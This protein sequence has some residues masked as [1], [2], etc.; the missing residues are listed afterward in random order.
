MAKASDEFVR[1][2]GERLT[3]CLTSKETNGELLEMEVVYSPNSPRPPEHY[4]PSQEEHFEA[5]IG[6]LYTEIGGQRRTYEA[7]DSFTVPI[8]THHGCTT[9]ARNLGRLSGRYDRR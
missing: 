6:T 3:F 2:Y 7:G 5:L 8:G 9:P 4:H 1:P